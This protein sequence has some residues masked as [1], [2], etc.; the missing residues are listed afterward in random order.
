M[1]CRETLE[2]V[3][4]LKCQNAGLRRLSHVGKLT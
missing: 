3:D 2:A 1:G 4:L